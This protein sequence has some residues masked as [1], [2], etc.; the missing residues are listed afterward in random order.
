[1]NPEEK[2][3]IAIIDD[4]IHTETPHG[5]TM[6][7]IIQKLE[8]SGLVV[9]DVGSLTDAR[10]AAAQLP[11]IDCILIN[12]DLGGDSQQNHESTT[13]II[14][15]IRR[16]NDELP[17][18]LLAEPASQAPSGLTV[19]I[20][21]EI[22]EYVYA[23]DDTPDFLAGRITA[24]ARRYREQMLSPFFSELIKFSRDFEYSWHTPGHAGGTAFRKTPVGRAFHTFFGEQLFRSD[25]SISVDE[26]GSLLD[27]SGPIGKAEKYAAKVFGADKTYFVTNGTS[28]AN[29]IVFFGAVTEGDVVLVDRNCHKSAEHALTMTHSVP[30]YLIPSRNR[31]GIIGPI[32]PDQLTPDA[33]SKK[34]Q[35]CPFTKY[36]DSDHP[37]HAII[38][39][40][41]YDGLCYHAA[42]VEHLLGQT[43]DRIHFDEAWYGYA[44][45]NPL[46]RDR[47]AMRNGAKD[48]NGPT[49]FA[50][51]STHKLLAALSQASMVHVRNGRVPIE[52]SRF[53][54][55]FM[56]HTSTSPLYTIIASLDVSAK[57]MDGPSGKILTDECIEEAIR[58]RR[59]MAR[60]NR[61]IGHRETPSDWWFGMWQPDAVTDP[62]S[63]KRISFTDAPLEILRDNPSCWVLHPGENWHGFEGL[64]D[65]YCMLDPIKVTIL[66]PGVAD[67]GRLEPFGIPAALVVKFLDTR[68][69][70]N[71]KS[72]DYS[73]LFLFSVGITKGKWGTLIT[74]LFEFKRLYD[75]NTLLEEIFPDL[76]ESY[77][78]RYSGMTLPE[79]AEEM[80]AFKRDHRMLE[81]LSQAFSLLPEPVITFAD[82]YKRLV[83]GTVEQVPVEKM[84]GRVVATGVVPYPPGIP[85][86]LPGERA[87]DQNGP[88]L[89]YL[90]G[91]QDFD[92]RFPG[93]NHDTHGVEVVNG[94]YL[95]SCIKEE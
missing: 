89:E 2:L 6:K 40:S 90:K 76:I 39:N 24:A 91:L 23:M 5:R 3:T 28:T 43:V 11:G 47:F 30:V 59:T 22:N 77:P 26:L 8:E 35:A 45:F 1:M 75:E 41:T 44:R 14:H 7:R 84:G 53:N 15:E 71:E 62:K 94:Q 49:V 68:G 48:S 61:E 93:F 18:F 31:Y 65:D 27:H 58:F 36:A 92:S 37:V 88:I 20:I 46:Y 57:M 51:Q 56:M 17:I 55:G 79:L 85:L 4:A 42:R 13:K 64:E 83:R 74:E 25:L 16:R 38:T 82:A 50:T 33:I 86:L 32:H 73:I 21:K 69:I 78:D 67:D 60:I 19:E 34:V 63:G 52:H 10:A 95:V 54:E 29:K 81:T 70:I 87:G 66:T 9:G 72:G 80:H 12:W